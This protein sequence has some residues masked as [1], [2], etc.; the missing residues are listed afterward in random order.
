M[1]VE[2]IAVARLRVRRIVMSMQPWM[3]AFRRAPAPAPRPGQG[4]RASDAQTVPWRPDGR[5]A[6]LFFLREKVARSAG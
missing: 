3:A 2:S 4:T 6:Y 5:G 1:R